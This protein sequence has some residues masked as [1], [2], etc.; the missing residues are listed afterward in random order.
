MNFKLLLD[1]ANDCKCNLTLN[2]TKS[3]FRT[4][5]LDMLGYRISHNQVKP[6]LKDYNLYYTPR[7]LSLLKNSNVSQACVPTIPNGFQ[8]YL[9][10]LVLRY[11]LPLFPLRMK[12]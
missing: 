8:S 6:D 2:K 9:R 5:I 10:R 7:R 1:T 12:P 11:T 3:N 4:T